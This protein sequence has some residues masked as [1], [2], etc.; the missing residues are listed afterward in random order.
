MKLNYW[1]IGGTILGAALAVWFLKT[2][3]SVIVGAL[4]V[5]GFATLALFAMRFAKSYRG[6]CEVE[7]GW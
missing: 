6:V 1:K 3:G 7:G 5:V 4:A 2:W